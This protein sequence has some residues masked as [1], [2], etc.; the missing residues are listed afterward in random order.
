MKY[1]GECLGYG[2]V[3]VNVDCI[4]GDHFPDHI[5]FPDSCLTF[6]R[7]AANINQPIFAIQVW[8][9]LYHM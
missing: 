7:R 8:H 2:K 5:K 1:P 6:P 4:H 3:R 9:I